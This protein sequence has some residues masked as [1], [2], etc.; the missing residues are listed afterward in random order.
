M[1][2]SR[3]P[4]VAGWHQALEARLAVTE[5]IPGFV[6]RPA[7][8]LRRPPF[9]P[10]YLEECRRV[11]FNLLGSGA[12]RPRVIAVVSAE[13][14]EG[15]SLTAAGVAYVAGEDT[16]ST[17]LLADLD[18][19]G[20]R[21]PALFGIDPS[22]GLAEYLEGY[23]SLRLVTGGHGGRLR[24]LPG[25]ER[26]AALPAYLLKQV[27]SSGMIDACRDQ[28]GLVILDLPPL[29]ESPEAVQL[30]A[31]ADAHLVVGRYR[32]TTLASVRRVCALLGSHGSRPS[33]VLVGQRSRIPGWARRLI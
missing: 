23:P 18:L 20:P 14:G 10:R 33:F 9:S 31:Q 21:L 7:E 1:I 27:S 28:F 26:T 19:E 4:A 2:H 12:A 8:R 22:P 32:Y 24:L 25:G 5:P 30:A 16:D 13:R 17:V 6:R 11:V 29:L 15:R 3:S